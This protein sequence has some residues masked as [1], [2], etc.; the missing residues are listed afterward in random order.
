M[1]RRNIPVEE[2]SDSGAPEWMVT[3]SDCMTLLLTFFV[4]LLSFSSFDNKEFKKLKVIYSNAFSSIY[5][6]NRGSK[7]ALVSNP[8]IMPTSELD[9]GSEK[10]TQT[11]GNSDGSLNEQLSDDLERGMVFLFPSKDMFWGNGSVISTEGQELLNDLAVF[12]SEVPNRIVITEKSINN[13]QSDEL[14]GLQR[15]WSVI[16]YLS[17]K[18]NISKDRFSISIGGTT[19]NKNKYTNTN[20]NENASERQLEISLLE[21][22]IYN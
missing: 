18:H 17:S 13:N 10:T 14:S 11:E 8:Q 20:A 6:N 7:D 12:I 2:E 3:F 16:Y 1:G 21:R 4:L 5:H 9:S 15:A 19:S 22:S